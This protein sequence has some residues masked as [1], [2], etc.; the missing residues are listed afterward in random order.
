[1]KSAV[2]IY[3]I[4]RCIREVVRAEGP[5]RARHV[6]R[7]P[8]PRDGERARLNQAVV[9]FLHGGVHRPMPRLSIITTPN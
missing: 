3:V 4:S 9:F 8:P 7:L 6:F 5:N 2:Y 1:M